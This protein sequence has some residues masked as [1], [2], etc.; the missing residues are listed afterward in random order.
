MN[1]P[2]YENYDMRSFLAGMEYQKQ[3][4]KKERKKEVLSNPSTHDLLVKSKLAVLD[5]ESESFVTKEVMK[6]IMGNLLTPQ[7]YNAVLR[8]I[9]CREVK[10]FINGTQKNGWLFTNEAINQIHNIQN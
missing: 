9:G 5:F 7:K 1:Y 4:E 2:Q 10:R 3:L 6:V 8:H